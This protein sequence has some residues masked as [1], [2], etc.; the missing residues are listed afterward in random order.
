[1]TAN[2]TQHT[3]DGTLL[4]AEWQTSLPVRWVLNSDKPHHCD[5][6]LSFGGEYVSWEAMLRATNGAVP[7]F[8]PA[9]SRPTEMKNADQLVACWDACQCSLQ[10][11]INGEWTHVA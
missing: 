8:F 4:P 11:N 1:M 10:V 7:G 2:I 6:C 3:A 5:A 9:C